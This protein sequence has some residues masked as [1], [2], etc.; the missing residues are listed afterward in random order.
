MF[1][2]VHGNTTHLR[3]AVTLGLVLVVRTASLQDRLVDTTATSDDSNHSTVVR[4]QDLLGA[5][6]QLDTGTLGVRVVSDHGSVVTR[7]TGQ[8]ATVTGLLLQVAHDGTFGHQTDWQNVSD[9]Q[10]G[11]LSAVHELAGVHT[12]GG[13]EELL[14]QLELVAVTEVDDRQ[15]GTTTWIMDDLLDDS[16]Q[17][18]VTFGIVEG[19]QFWLSLS[20]LG[21]GSEDGPGTFTLCTNDAPHC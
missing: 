19:A 15:R 14:A 6:R 7:G 21:V 5:R 4:G 13:N 20:L 10:L 1:N 3:P 2:G 16:L 9:L 8:L 12:F 11:A 18:T 17:V